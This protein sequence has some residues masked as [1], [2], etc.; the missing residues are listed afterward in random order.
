MNNLEPVLLSKSDFDCVGQVAKHCDWDQLCIYIREQQNLSLLPKVG[1]CI[2]DKLLK[3][4][5]G[6]YLRSDKGTLQEESHN[7]LNHL[8]NGGRYRSCD[9][10]E[11][12]HYGLKRVLVHWTYGAYLYRHGFV[13]TA[14]GVV[15]K[16]NENSLPASLR[17]LEKINVEQRSNA[18]YYWKLTKDYLCSI[19]DC[20]VLADCNICDCIHDCKCNSCKSCKTGGTQ[21]RRGVNFKTISR[22]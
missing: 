16:L 18:E 8:F 6:W 19:K 13:D 10:S 21:Q 17:D 22:H 3:Y 15:Q 11:K 2:F 9:G 1:Q 14:F 20:E 12:V 7:T 4:C 5:Q